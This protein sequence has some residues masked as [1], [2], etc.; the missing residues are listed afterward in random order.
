MFFLAS[1]M[2]TFCQK[3][4]WATKICVQAVFVSYALEF[5]SGSVAPCA[6]VPCVYVCLREAQEAFA[7]L[8]AC[9]RRVFPELQLYGSEDEGYGF[10]FDTSSAELVLA[11]VSNLYPIE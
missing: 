4:F 2:H 9:V 8:G 1:L 5:K 11:A 3:G 10:D 7:G 6:S